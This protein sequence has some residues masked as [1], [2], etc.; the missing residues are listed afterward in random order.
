MKLD[1]LK[2]GQRSRIIKIT[3]PDPLRQ[4]LATLGILK[5]FEVSLLA[6]S[7]LGDPK[8]YRLGRQQVCLRNE[9]A[10]C[11]EVEVIEG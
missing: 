3:G 11:V 6:V 2:R 9:D 4:R 7:P 8:A 1:T 5:G 10:A